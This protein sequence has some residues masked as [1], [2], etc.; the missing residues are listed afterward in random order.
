M[1]GSMNKLNHILTPSNSW[2]SSLLENFN[3]RS[4]PN[5]KSEEYK[6]TPIHNWYS[7]EFSTQNLTFDDFK[8]VSHEFAKEFIEKFNKFD[9]TVHALH[10][11]QVKNF[12]HIELRNSNLILSETLL[13]SNIS[14]ATLLVDA[15]DNSELIESIACLENS[16]LNIS[17]YINVHAK[18]FSFYKIDELKKES[19][20]HSWVNANCSENCE[21]FS[22]LHLSSNEGS[23]RLNQ[24]IKINSRE[25]TVDSH[26]FYNLSTDSNQD[27]YSEI[28][29]LAPNT[30]SDQTVKGILQ[31]NARNVFT[32]K[33]FID[34][35]CSGV[36]ANQFN[37]NLVFGKKAQAI[38]QPQLEIYN[39][40][41]KCSH[42]STTGQIDENEI[43]YFMARGMSKK[44]A[45]EMLLASYAEDFLNKCSENA[46]KVLRS[47]YE[48]FLKE[49]S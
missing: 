37:K 13:N 24:K 25:T 10:L 11:S 23:N 22:L 1:I 47:K 31:E 40:D 14:H 30:F 6:F 43:F 3:D 28:F 33:I 29:H 45:T 36:D 4:F 19:K 16:F 27:I 39:D 48:T 18:N 46:R 38:S 41:V 21:Q 9:S 42:G 5:R 12:F 7:H 8:S 49:R 15:Y 26:S 44:K 20:K 32:G 17:I 35:G 2:Q 34:H